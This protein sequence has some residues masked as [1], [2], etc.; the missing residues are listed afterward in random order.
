MSGASSHA[1]DEDPGDA[2]GVAPSE[3]VRDER[4]LAAISRG[5][6]AAFESL[7]RSH[8]DRIHAYLLRLTGS[9]TDAEDLAQETFLR[10]WQK[11]GHYQP[12]RV[13]VT[14]WLHT[15]AH[16]LAIDSFRKKRE[17][18][19]AQGLE[20]SDPLADPALRQ[21]AAEQQRLLN[22]ALSNLPERQRAA[23][24]LC[25]VQGFSNTQAAEI[26]GVKVRAL[27]SLLA[28]GRKALRES[29][30]QSGALAPQHARDN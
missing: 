30:T 24:L 4:L 5:D 15:I 12:G 10:V 26:L 28:R 27:E 6:S 7:V 25:Q 13:K 17:L 14:T 23:V 20:M 11:A 22:L 29:L 8:L 1:D 19:E 3:L 16:R 9:R 2:S 18:P 21:A